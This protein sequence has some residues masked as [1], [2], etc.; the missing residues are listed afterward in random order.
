M[1]GYE[2]SGTAWMLTRAV[3]AD[4]LMHAWLRM[5]GYEH[6]P[7]QVEEVLCHLMAYQWL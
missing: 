5:E 6:L 3:L 2:H 1:E 7:Q 4:E